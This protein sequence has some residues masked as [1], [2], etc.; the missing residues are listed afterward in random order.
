[1]GKPNAGFCEMEILRLT[2]AFEKADQ[3]R[4]TLNAHISVQHRRQPLTRV[5][6]LKAHAAP[7]SVCANVYGKRGHCST[8]WHD[9]T[10]ITCF[11]ASL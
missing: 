6:V 2:D 10:A 5:T 9:N 8:W 1:M 4:R 3:H 11:H 7:L